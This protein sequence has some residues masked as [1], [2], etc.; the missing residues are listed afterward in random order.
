MISLYPNP[1][2]I[3]FLVTLVKSFLGV[4]EVCSSFYMY[5]FRELFFFKSTL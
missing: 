3:T 4:C 1:S 2:F 5:F